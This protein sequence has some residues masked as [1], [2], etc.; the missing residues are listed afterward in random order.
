M[1]KNEKI[2]IIADHIVFYSDGKV[3]RSI[4]EREAADYLR[5]KGLSSI[6][7]HEASLSSVGK[8]LAMRCLG[9]PMC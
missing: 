9:T 8:K 5:R 7:I 6:F 3:G 2:Q 4:A 1:S